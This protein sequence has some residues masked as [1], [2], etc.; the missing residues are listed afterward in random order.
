M[1]F[2]Q[3]CIDLLAEIGKDGHRA[4]RPPDNGGFQLAIVC[5]PFDP[6]V[7]IKSAT[8]GHI[9]YWGF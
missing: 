1:Q 5:P 4:A 7:L 2:A 9:S 6:M 8:E 3:D